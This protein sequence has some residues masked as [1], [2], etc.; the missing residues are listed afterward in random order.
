MLTNATA[1]ARHTLEIGE[2]V[3]AFAVS[4][5]QNV[6]FST[7]ANVFLR[8]AQWGANRLLFT[9]KDEVMGLAFSLDGET[10]ASCGR[11]HNLVVYNLKARRLMGGPVSLHSEALAVAFLVKEK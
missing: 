10:L 11:D 2:T 5:A 3:D 8:D 6:A 1:S 7:G 9:H 4:G